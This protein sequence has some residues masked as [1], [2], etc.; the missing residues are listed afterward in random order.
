MK[1]YL[2]GRMTGLPNFNFQAFEDACF[3]LRNM[4]GL[5]VVSPHEIDHGETEE[6]RGNLPYTTYIK[7]GLKLLLE[8]DAIIL[9]DGWELSQGCLTELVTARAAGLDVYFLDTDTGV[10]STSTTGSIDD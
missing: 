8:C 2:A 9:M 3:H 4:M 6:T 1:F 5:E 7:A 10:L